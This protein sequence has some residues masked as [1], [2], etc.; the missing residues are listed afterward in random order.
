VQFP[1][2]VDEDHG[3]AGAGA[4][5]EPER[6]PVVAFDV[7]ALLGVEERAPC[8]E[9][10]VLDGP[11]QLLVVLDK[12]ELR[13]CRR[14]LERRQELLIAAGF[15]PPLLLGALERELLA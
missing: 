6:S 1:S 2:A 15:V 8:G 11:A 3:L 13:P 5:R 14:V 4:A 12:C 9:V 10:P 7:A